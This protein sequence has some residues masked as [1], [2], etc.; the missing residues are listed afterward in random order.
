MPHQLEVIKFR[1]LL[2]VRTISRLVPGMPEP[3]LEIIG[4]DLSKAITVYINEISSPEFLIVSKKKIWA[5]LPKAAQS[6]IRTVEIAS[7]GFTKTSTP[8]RVTFEIGNKTSTVSGILKLV[9]LFTK[10]ILQSPGSDL[11]NPNR[12]GGLQNIVGKL[13]T[14]RDMQPISASITRAVTTTVTQ[15][16]AAQINVP[17]LPL[18]ERLLSAALINLRVYEAQMQAVANVSIQSVAGTEAVSALVL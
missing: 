10:W 8:S 9:Q 11:L 15:I 17:R 7:S 2:P 13:S 12:G 6:E 16:R 4:D 1:D 5:Q 18:S 3:T 14:T